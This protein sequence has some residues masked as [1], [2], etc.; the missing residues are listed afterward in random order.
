MHLSEQFKLFPAQT[1]DDGQWLKVVYTVQ[2]EVNDCV[3][4]RDNSSLTETSGE[5]WYKCTLIRFTL[6]TRVTTNEL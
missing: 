4:P 6:H 5:Q 2:Q 1:C 3:I